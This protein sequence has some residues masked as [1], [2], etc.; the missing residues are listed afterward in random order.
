MRQDCNFQ[1]ESLFSVHAY[2]WSFV[3]STLDFIDHGFESS[4][5]TVVLIL[6]RD[7]SIIILLFCY[8]VLVGQVNVEFLPRLNVRGPFLPFSYCR[9]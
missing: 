3:T 4:G 2:G 8:M 9:T 5:V 1:S 6:V 7:I